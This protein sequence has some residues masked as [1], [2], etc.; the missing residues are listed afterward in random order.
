MKI[1]IWSKISVLH[2]LLMAYCGVSIYAQG[3]TITTSSTPSICYNDG[4]LT[5][6]A[7]GGTAPY[8]DTIINGPNN[9][10]LTYPIGLAAGLSTF[11]NL[12]HGVFTIVV[13]DAAG[14]RVVLIDSVPGTYQFPLY[15]F[16]PITTDLLICTPVPGTGRGAIQYAISAT[17]S[18]SGFGLYQSSDT[19][20]HLCPGTYWVRMRDS[21]GN[22]YTDHIAFTYHLSL[23]VLCVNYTLGTL[24]V[25]AT[26]GNG[27]YRYTFRSI[28][29]S[30]LY[31][32]AT[33]H[34]TGITPGFR[35]YVAAY[36]S[37]VADSFS[38]IQGYVNLVEHCPFDSIIYLASTFSNILSGTDSVYITCTDC[39][40]PQ[41]V[42][43]LFGSSIPLFQYANPTQNYQFVALTSKCGR[44]TL[45][46]NLSHPSTSTRFLTIKWQACNSF[47][48]YYIDQTTHLSLS[49]DSFQVLDGTTAAVLA[50]VIGP[51]TIGYFHHLP[52]AT[53]GYTVVGYT[54][55]PCYKYKANINFPNLSYKYEMLAD[56]TCHYTWHVAIVPPPADT[57]DHFWLLTTPPDSLRAITHFDPT[58]PS[59]F[60]IPPGT[61]HIISD[62]GCSF[63]ITL[64]QIPA[65]QNI[66]AS[67]ITSYI[68][69][70]GI[71]YIHYVDTNMTQS[72][73]YSQLLLVKLFNQ[74][75]SLLTTAQGNNNLSFTFS[76]TDSGWY[77]FR[78]YAYHP[79]SI[80]PDSSVFAN[81]T[82][83]PI[84][85]GVVYVSNSHFPYP[86]AD[87]IYECG[88]A[89]RPTFTIYGGSIPYTVEIPG[90]DTLIIT[91][92]TAPFPTSVPGQYTM[93]VYDNCGISR[94]YT[95][96]VIDS[97]NRVICTTLRAGND[98]T[99]CRGQSLLLRPTVSRSGGK[100]YW[101]PS[102][103]T[104]ATLL[105]SPTTTTTYRV[106]YS[107]TGCNPVFDTITV[108][109]VLAPRVSATPDTTVCARATV[110]LTATPSLPGGSYAWQPGAATASTISVAPVASTPYRVIYTIAGC[111]PALDTAF[112]TVFTP[113]TITITPTA[114]Q[115]YGMADGSLTATVSP[116]GSYTYHWAN[117]TTSPID[118]PL[119]TGSYTLTVIDTHGCSTT[120]T[121][122]VSSTVA[123]P[124]LDILPTDTAVLLGATIQL[125]TR[126]VGYPTSSITGYLWSPTLGL[127]CYTCP[128][129]VLNTSSADSTHL[130][131]YSVLLTY[132]NG[133]QVSAYDTVKIKPTC[134][135][136]IAIPNAFTPNGDD[137]N[138][139]FK[140][141]TRGVQSFRMD[142]YNR[143]G[144]LLFQ[145]HDANIGWDGRY[146]GE[147]QSQEKY[148]AIV[149]ITFCDGTTT[150]RQSIFTLLR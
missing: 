50:T 110:T 48:A 11:I 109:V 95:F 47:S 139:S 69:C 91:T 66:A 36:D 80:Y 127:S 92:N 76:V 137:K 3:V 86:Y 59:F 147:M 58:R 150:T 44:D 75:D 23:S 1:G 101:I 102:G 37:C 67:Y 17:G 90:L 98:T 115:C 40:P 70:N 56:S 126:F 111:T 116:T 68:S 84:D 33:G 97:C 31:T 19:F 27:T 34:F 12:P 54:H 106:S 28:S 122:T 39:T 13:H 112:I 24:D 79:P 83:C 6:H 108:V 105:V 81:D 7:T 85:T 61:Y 145:S 104:T 14:H 134:D 141:K 60:G 29:P 73:N 57:T 74:H 107:I 32:S 124:I 45:K 16:A 20:K 149:Y 103:D 52:L 148:N 53:G 55:D 123:P 113:P 62:S 117:N 71:R 138:E 5:I 119:G 142:I 25:V 135:P 129:P 89:T 140:I 10:N 94:S 51:D 22:I 78:L 132:A 42:A 88:Q 121:A 8:I 120:A 93:I 65:F 82:L 15:N 18:N 35:G 63:P 21:C 131:I 128:T 96:G 87:P 100:Y 38:L 30:T 26:G 118:S 136:A 133:C 146:K 9:P 72:T 49:F 143:W 64:P 125:H 41:S 144:E 99:I 114:I 2:L 46:V 4:S 43:Y 77:H 130:N